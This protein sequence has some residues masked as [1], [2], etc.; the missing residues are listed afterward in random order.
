MVDLQLQ[1]ETKLGLDSK[2]LCT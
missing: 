2:C 1:V